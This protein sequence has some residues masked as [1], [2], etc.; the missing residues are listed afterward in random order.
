MFDQDDP[1]VII[2]PNAVMR[3]SVEATSSVRFFR[4]V[5]M[6]GLN[7]CI[8]FLSDCA[9]RD[10][11]DELY[12]EFFSAEDGLTDATNSH[13]EPNENLTLDAPGGRK[14]N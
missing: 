10:A 12:P 4:S 5:G 7:E 3:H 13:S 14:W 11:N 6:D 9:S 8:Q 1:A 2:S